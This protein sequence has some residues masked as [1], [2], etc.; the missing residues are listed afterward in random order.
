MSVIP[1]VWFDCDQSGPDCGLPF[2]LPDKRGDPER[3]DGVMIGRYKRQL[4]FNYRRIYCQSFYLL[5]I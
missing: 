3:V 2:D 5:I 4:N 1:L